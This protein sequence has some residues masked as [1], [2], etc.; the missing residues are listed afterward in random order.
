MDWEGAIRGMSEKVE[1]GACVPAALKD[2]GIDVPDSMFIEAAFSGAMDPI[3]VAERLGYVNSTQYDLDLIKLHARLKELKQKGVL[4]FLRIGAPSHFGVVGQHIN[5]VIESTNLGEKL[6]FRLGGI[7]PF[8][9][10]KG[11]TF[12]LAVLEKVVPENGIIFLTKKVVS[13]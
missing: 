1:V 4:P 12:E 8:G 13:P 3:K 5:S 6:A 7:P 2:A 9:K 10:E 11:D